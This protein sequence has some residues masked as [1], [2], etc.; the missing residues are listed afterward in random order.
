MVEDNVSSKTD[1]IEEIK[2]YF[3]K[4]QRMMMIGSSINK[5]YNIAIKLV[6]IENTDNLNEMTE[7]GLET[8]DLTKSVIEVIINESH[9]LHDEINEFY[10][11]ID[12]VEMTTEECIEFFGFEDYFDDIKSKVPNNSSKFEADKHEL[13]LL[14]FQFNNK[15]KDFFGAI[16]SLK[17]FDI[18]LTYLV[19][20]YSDDYELQN[21]D[22]N[23][24]IKIG[25]QMEGNILKIK[26]N[27]EE[28][29]IHLENGIAEGEVFRH[30]LYLALKNFQSN[31]KLDIKYGLNQATSGL[32]N[33]TLYSV[34]SFLMIYNIF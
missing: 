11:N 18:F 13:D 8:Y 14:V 32:L 17:H 20:E 16:Y 21:L 28:K 1:E 4:Y 9:E 22:T 7:M 5:F 3:S 6:P 10:E 34:L 29:F 25:N 27:I 31:E 30:R 26:E 19:S 33:T 15:M 2:I 12:K 24:K 23:D